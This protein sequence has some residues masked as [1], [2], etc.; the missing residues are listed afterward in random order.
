M[1]RK[2]QGFA[3]KN[4]TSDKGILRRR[5]KRGGDYFLQTGGQPCLV[6]QGADLF[7]CGAGQYLCYQVAE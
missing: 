1:Q 3:E 5:Q 4:T 6:R 7:F 2:R